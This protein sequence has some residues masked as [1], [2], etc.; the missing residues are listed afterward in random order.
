MKLP[1]RNNYIDFAKA[2]G[3]KRYIISEGQSVDLLESFEN[4]PLSAGILNIGPYFMLLANVNTWKTLFI[5]EGC[6]KLTGYTIKEA[7][8]LGPQLMVNF[9]HPDDYP[10]AMET[11]KHAVQMLYEAEPD[12]RPFFSC[13][14]YHRGIQKNGTV[15]KIMQHIVPIT[16]DMLGNPYV[17]AIVITDISHM[18][19]PRMTKT[20]MIDHKRNNYQL[21]EPGQAFVEG[22]KLHLSVRE[23][24]V[25]KLLAEGYTTKEIASELGITFNTAATYRKRLRQKTGVKTTGE[26]VNYALVQALI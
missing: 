4:N 12:D 1:L 26:L 11:N 9:T 16:F 15:I 14:F 6:E 25:L 2:L 8:V 23:T 20:V 13:I 10:L 18:Q 5:S 19:M 7:I 21:I 3:N 24:E 17:F 22:K